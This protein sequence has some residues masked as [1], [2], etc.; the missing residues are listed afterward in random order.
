M[1]KKFPCADI[2]QLLSLV[3]VFLTVH[4]ELTTH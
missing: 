2:L 1:I 4:H 3:N